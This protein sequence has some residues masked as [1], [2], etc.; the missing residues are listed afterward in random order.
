M[1]SEQGVVIAC[2]SKAEF[3]AHMTKAQEAGKLVVIDFT[4]AWCGPCRAIAPL[5]VEHAK[6]F[7]QVVFLKVDVDEVKEVTAAYEVEAMPTFHFVKNGKTV[8]TIVGARKDE[9]LAQIE[10]HAAPAPA[11]ASA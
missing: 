10:K 1:A 11:S 7:T 3:D 8:A 6:K 2:H 5:F 9:L 4:A